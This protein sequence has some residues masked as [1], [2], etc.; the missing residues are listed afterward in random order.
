MNLEVLGYADALLG[1]A[2]ADSGLSLTL[3]ARH[4]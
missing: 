4:W 1:R 3:L 2:L